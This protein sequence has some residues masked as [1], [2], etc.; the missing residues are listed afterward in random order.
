MAA[1]SAG[2]F[3]REHRACAQVFTPARVR[4]DLPVVIPLTSMPGIVGG[5]GQDF[6]VPGE[7]AMDRP[8]TLCGL[9]RRHLTRSGDLSAISRPPI[10]ALPDQRREPRLLRPTGLVCGTT[11]QRS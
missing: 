1:S 9:R 11:K 6:D 5:A 2:S 3:P 8:L 7:P 4:T 10:D